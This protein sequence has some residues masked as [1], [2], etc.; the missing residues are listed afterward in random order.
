MG[1]FLL[2]RGRLLRMILRTQVSGLIR[3]GGLGRLDDA[4]QQ[5]LDG[6][7]LA[8]HALDRNVSTVL[9][10]NGLGPGKADAGARDTQGAVLAR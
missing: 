9:L 5:H 3:N 10:Y 7:T 8:D 6:R 1:S 4:R 2:W